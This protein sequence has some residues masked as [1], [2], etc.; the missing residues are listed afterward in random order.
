LVELSQKRPSAFHAT[1]NL[2]VC[3]PFFVHGPNSSLLP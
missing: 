2:E 3:C 1:M